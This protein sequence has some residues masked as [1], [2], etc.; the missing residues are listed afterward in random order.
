MSGPGPGLGW[1]G[2]AE[3]AGSDPSGSS[4]HPEEPEQSS[5]DATDSNTRQARIY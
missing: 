1:L 3:A 5:G 4:V 2:L